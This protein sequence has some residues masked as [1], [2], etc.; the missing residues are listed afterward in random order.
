M[1]Q[2]HLNV[3]VKNGKDSFKFIKEVHIKPI[4]MGKEQVVRSSMRKHK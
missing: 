4:K 2:V 3:H 1:I